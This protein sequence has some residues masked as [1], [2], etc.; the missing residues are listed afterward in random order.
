MFETRPRFR[1]LERATDELKNKYG[2]AIIG[3]AASFSD[4]GLQGPSW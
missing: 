3:R 1:E 2:D 4:A